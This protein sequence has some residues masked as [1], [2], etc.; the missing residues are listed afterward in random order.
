MINFSYLIFLFA[1]KDK[2]FRKI[3]SKI[4]NYSKKNRDLQKKRKKKKR[5][6]ITFYFHSVLLITTFTSFRA[7]TFIG[8][9]KFSWPDEFDKFPPRRDIYI[10][11]YST[12]FSNYWCTVIPDRKFRIWKW[13]QLSMSI[14]RVTYIEA[15]LPL[16]RMQL[17]IFAGYFQ[18]AESSFLDSFW[19]IAPSAPPL[20][21]LPQI[22][23]QTV[24]KLLLSSFLPPPFVK[25]QR[26]RD[27]ST[28]YS[29][30]WNTI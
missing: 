10:Y 4:T 5:S 22:L 15:N 24:A 11:I 25:S 27:S 12:R 23:R 9:D 29:T 18:P 16:T 6:R 7:Q 14:V 20:P 1:A 21:P 3:Y 17:V 8:I 2:K 26:Q 19:S 13:K 30:G 28:Y